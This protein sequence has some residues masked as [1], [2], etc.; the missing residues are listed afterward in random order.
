MQTLPGPSA[1]F[2]STFL[3]KKYF[4]EGCSF[5]KYLLCTDELT[6]GNIMP[7]LVSRSSQVTRRMSGKA[8][9]SPDSPGR[10][11]SKGT[12]YEM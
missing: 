3:T 11:E 9:I 8:K 1:A 6:G 10:T 7:I 2:L 4:E 12:Q 5:S